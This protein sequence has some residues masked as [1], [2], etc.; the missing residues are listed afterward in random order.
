M[1]FYKGGSGGDHPSVASIEFLQKV[2]NQTCL[3]NN[4]GEIENVWT[5]TGLGSYLL[6]L[7]LSRF[8][9]VYLAG[10]T[11]IT[12]LD[13]STNL[14]EYFEVVRRPLDLS[15][16]YT[17]EEVTRD[18]EVTMSVCCYDL[19][20][21]E[22]VG[23]MYVGFFIHGMTRD[24]E[25]IDIPLSW[26]VTNSS[27]EATFSFTPGDFCEAP[28]HLIPY[29]YFVAFC[30]ETSVTEYSQ[31]AVLLDTRHPTRLELLGSEVTQATV[32]QPQYL[33]CRLV[34]ADTGA[35]VEG[36][37]ILFYINGTYNWNG[38]TDNNGL[39]LF[40][41]TIPYSGLWFF[42][43][44]FS[45]GEGYLDVDCEN[46]NNVTF[47]LVAVSQPVFVFFDVQPRDF[48][49]GTEITLSATVYDAISNQ[50]LQGFRVWFYW[51][52]NDGSNGTIG[53]DDTDINGVASVT[54]PYPSSGI[55]VF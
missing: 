16:S 32:G 53:W 40:E 48:R 45:W 36:R 50:T 5:P 49:P 44:Q 20:L 8:F 15:V 17:P 33:G 39:L 4:L 1:T 26:C 19:G 42:T 18:D 13:A 27:G 22:P 2:L 38:T 23:Q 3:S 21:G 51:Y 55:F 28:F 12:G 54:W 7:K 29:F 30:F 25:I 41:V 6:Q 11:A 14:V 9:D 46:S 43:M 47:V 37:P 24:E 34:R 52:A 10:Q 35:P 31:T